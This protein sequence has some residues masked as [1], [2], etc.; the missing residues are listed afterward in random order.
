MIEKSLD[1]TVQFGCDG[2][3]KV[4]VAHWDSGSSDTFSGDP[5]E[6]IA[7]VKESVGG[8]IGLW[9]EEA[10]EG[11]NSEKTMPIDRET[12]TVVPRKS[13]VECEKTACAYNNN[14]TCRFH[15][16]AER[17]PNRD[18]EGGCEE[19]TPKAKRPTRDCLNCGASMSA[20]NEDGN[21]C[22]VCSVHDYKVVPENGYCSDWN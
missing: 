5:E 9:Q 11:M 20:D 16:V 1:V 12:T 2:S 6:V 8:W 14:A 13:A 4:S 7:Q 22:L 3:I 10:A 19:F 18:N 21:P 17:A 15:L